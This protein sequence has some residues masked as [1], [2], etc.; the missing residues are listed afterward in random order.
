MLVTRGPIAAAPVVTGLGDRCARCGR[1]AEN[2]IAPAVAGYTADKHAET[3]WFCGPGT[4]CW[5]QQRD[6]ALD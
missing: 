1:E 4:Q 3:L 2:P 6:E 5:R